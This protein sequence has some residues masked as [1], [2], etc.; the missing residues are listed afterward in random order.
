[1]SQDPQIPSTVT[2]NGKSL[3]T[4]SAMMEDVI[5]KKISNTSIL[6]DFKGELIEYDIE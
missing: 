1:M 5:V 3:T 6:F 2:I 4:G